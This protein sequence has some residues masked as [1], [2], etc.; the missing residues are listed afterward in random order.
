ML[1]QT[2]IYPDVDPFTT[3]FYNVGMRRQWRPT[4]TIGI[5]E[6]WRHRH[7]PWPKLKTFPCMIFAFDKQ[8]NACLLSWKD[9]IDDQKSERFW[10]KFDQRALRW[11][12]FIRSL[13]YSDDRKMRLYVMPVIKWPNFRY[14][15]WFLQVNQGN[16]RACLVFKSGH[17][18]KWWF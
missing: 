11:Y 16:I 17:L 12:L 9:F 15:S 4:K 14:Y 8:Y 6:Y 3:M 5:E 13:S 1:M 7:D 2:L 10:Y 18:L